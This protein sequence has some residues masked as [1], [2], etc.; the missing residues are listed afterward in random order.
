MAIFVQSALPPGTSEAVS[1]IDKH[2]PWVGGVFIGGAALIWILKAD[3]IPWLKKR[4]EIREER[5]AKRDDAILG[6]MK[7]S[8]DRADAVITTLPTAI[9]RL[10]AAHEKRA[11][12]TDQKIDAVPDEVMKRI[13]ANEAKRK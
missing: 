2:G 6:E 3:V 8:G 5:M 9:D 11:D 10:I 1:F 13:M 4:A 12:R 7:R